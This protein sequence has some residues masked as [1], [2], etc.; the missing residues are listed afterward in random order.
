MLTI[1]SVAELPISLFG[2]YHC[3]GES[4]FHFPQLLD[5]KL[6]SPF[7]A[8]TRVFLDTLLS[9]YPHPLDSSTVVLADFL[10]G[11]PPILKNSFSN[12]ALFTNY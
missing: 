6:G 8:L 9:P 12:H 11:E 4:Q 7:G 3:C 2:K 5:T 10:A 1:Y